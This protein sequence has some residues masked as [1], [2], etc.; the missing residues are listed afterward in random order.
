MISRK[1]QW[2]RTMIDEST[3]RDF[4]KKCKNLTKYNF[5]V[6]YSVLFVTSVFI[7]FLLDYFLLGWNVEKIKYFITLNF[8]ILSAESGL[9]SGVDYYSNNLLS[10]QLFYL[11]IS[12]SLYI[13]YTVMF[14]KY[15]LI[16]ASY[17]AK[18]NKMD[19]IYV[20]I[21]L[22]IISFSALSFYIYNRLKKYDAIE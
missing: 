5:F 8:V 4:I 11:T 9:Y 7:C 16:D 3:E 15:V 19:G 20:G 6:F 13:I 21:F 2:V 10:R 17:S 12:C 14:H 18:S 22:F 1:R